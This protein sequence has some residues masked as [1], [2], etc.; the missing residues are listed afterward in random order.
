MGWSWG[1]GVVT[2]SVDSVKNG[3]S[4]ARFFLLVAAV[5]H[6]V[7]GVVGL[8]LNQSFPIGANA[9]A[10]A[11]SD[12]IFGVFE[13]NGWHSLAALL[14]GLLAAYFTISGHRVR[15]V[16]LGIGIVHVGIVAALVVWQPET[17]WLASNAADQFVH[18]STAI[19]G[20]VSGLA[21]TPRITKDGAGS[22][23]FVRKDR[24]FLKA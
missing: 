22:S 17:L 24:P 3:W 20:I 1:T 8:L 2:T 14:L 6:L 11:G 12:H 4:P 16:A 7:L 18:V 9:A 23:E 21:T 5:W 10:G 15:E 19:G 13:T